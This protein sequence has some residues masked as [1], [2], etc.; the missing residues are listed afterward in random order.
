MITVPEDHSFVLRL[1]YL[2]IY[3]ALPKQSYEDYSSL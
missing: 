1:I 3:Q 2:P